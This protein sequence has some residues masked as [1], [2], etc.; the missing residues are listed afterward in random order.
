MPHL[1]IEY[2][3]A[4]AQQIDLQE[5]MQGVFEAAVAAQVMRPEDI[6]VRA[7]P[8]RHFLLG[9]GGDGFVHV[10]VRL[11]AGRDAGQKRRL[12]ESLRTRLAALLPAVHSISV[13]IV[14]MDPDAYLKRLL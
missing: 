12:S 14:D 13:D 2:A 11:L 6:K 8:Y 5:L 9:D 7:L 10:T 4:V 1:I 3:E